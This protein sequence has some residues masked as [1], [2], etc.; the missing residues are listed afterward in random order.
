V[1]ALERAGATI[2]DVAAD[3]RLAVQAL[4][5]FDIQS[6]ILE[7]GAAVHEA[8]W[9]AG[10]VDFV[11]LYIAPAVIGEGGVPLLAGQPFSVAALLETRV[12]PL[13]PDVLIEGYVH[14]PH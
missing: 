10:V 14:R 1:Q 8:A 13:G 4:V 6:V 7:G 9:K 5:D 12:R 3:F 11:Q 2:V